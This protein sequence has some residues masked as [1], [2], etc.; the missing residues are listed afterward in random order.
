MDRKIYT[1]SCLIFFMFLSATG[2]TAAGNQEL[3][4][5]PGVS[6]QD[7]QSIR[8]SD[9]RGVSIELKSSPRRIVSLGP[10]ITET[11][12][13][14]GRADLLVGRTDFCDYPSE[15]A[16]I[17]S[18]GGLQDPNLETIVALN[19]D[20]VIASTHADPEVLEKL[21]SYSI[22]SV[23]IYGE[24]SFQGVEEVIRGCAEILN[25]REAGDELIRDIRDRLKAVE[26]SVASMK[27][28]PQCYY[29]L[30][31][32]EGGDWTSGG[33][34]F[35]SELLTMAG[36]V[37][38]A[39]DQEGWSYSKELLVLRQPEIVLVNRGARDDFKSLPVYGE[40]NASLGNMVFEIDENS[41]VRQGPRQIDALEEIHR[42]MEMVP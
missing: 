23:M 35:I 26:S 33:N 5:E 38:I 24:E 2:L 42:I 12:F 4:P 9:S 13:A 27:R 14:L 22:P 39:A 15:A 6:G 28:R 30:G 31:F 3:T 16:D 1:L 19:P 29:A 7:G 37:N 21:A 18:V 11:V 8:Y 41:L 10:N 34:T 32:G 25:A 40:L 36:G 17:E 20:L